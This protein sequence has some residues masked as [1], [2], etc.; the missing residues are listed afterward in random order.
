VDEDLFEPERPPFSLREDHR[1]RLVAEAARAAGVHE[2]QPPGERSLFT[3]V[4]Q[5]ASLGEHLVHTD[6][7]TPRISKTTGTTTCIAG[8][9]SETVRR[10]RSST[11]DTRR[12][13]SAWRTG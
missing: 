6:L 13:R 12:R 5:P 9:R 11:V 10:S 8:C 1:A 7:W 3:L 4:R 2:D